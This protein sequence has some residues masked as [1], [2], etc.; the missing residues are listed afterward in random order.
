[1][2][3]LFSFI[4]FLLQVWC[5]W[6]LGNN[7]KWYPLVSEEPFAQLAQLATRLEEVNSQLSGILEECLSEK[8]FLAQPQER[9]SLWGHKN[10]IPNRVTFHLL[11]GVYCME[12]N[13][14]GVATTMV[15]NGQDMA[16]VINKAVFISLLKGHNNDFNAGT[17]TQ[18]MSVSELSLGVDTIT[19]MAY[20]Y[21]RAVNWVKVEEVLMNAVEGD[22]WLDDGDIF[23]VILACS[24]A[25]LHE[26]SQSLVSKLYR[27]REY[28]QLPVSGNVE[29]AIENKEG[30]RSGVSLKA[31][32]DTK[33]RIEDVGYT[34][35]MQFLV[36][37]AEPSWS[38][39]KCMRLVELV[40]KEKGVDS[41]QWKTDLELLFKT[42]RANLQLE[43]SP[44][45]F[46]QT[47]DLEMLNPVLKEHVRLQIGVPAL[48]V[49]PAFSM[50]ATLFREGLGREKINREVALLSIALISTR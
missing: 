44:E 12:G 1:M 21:V 9:L 46:H 15:E 49:R 48:A 30:A 13:I 28:F 27:K 42:I 34:S 31:M 3:T 41:L 4:N 50:K 43:K 37:E 14:A 47:S 23:Y 32:L 25:G 20:S 19:A 5:D 16:M 36:Q 8:A 35:A 2:R 45:R 6:L 18:E 33:R 7:D 10:L 39:E 11:M 22:L 24:Q 17:T 29:T 26:E 38:E 40:K